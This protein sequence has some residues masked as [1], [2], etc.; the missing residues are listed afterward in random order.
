[1]AHVDNPGRGARDAVER[2]SPPGADSG[3]SFEGAVVVVD[4]SGYTPLAE[5]LCGEDRHGAERLGAI[6]DIGFRGYV[7]T[8]RD[9]GGQIACFAGD[10]FTAYWAAGDGDV[11]AALVR[12][13]DC[14][15]RLH[16]IFQHA[17]DTEADAQPPV[18]I[19][20]GSGRMWG[21]RLGVDDGI[22]LLLAGPAV[23][24]ACSALSHAN[25]GRT[26]VAPE[27]RPLL[28]SASSRPLLDPRLPGQLTVQ[29]VLSSEREALASKAP[30]LIDYAGA[31]FDAWIPQRRS[32]CALFVRIDGL[33]NLTPLPGVPGHQ[34][35]VVAIQ[36]ALRPYTGATGTLIFDDKGLVFNVC[37]GMPH[38]TH[39]DE[40]LEELREMAD[41]VIDTSSLNVHE[42]RERLVTQFSEDEMSR[43]MR[44]SIRSFGFKHGVPRDTA[45]AL[46]ERFLPNPHWVPELR[47]LRGI[48][49][50]V[51]E[52]VLRSEGAAEFMER[53]DDLLEFLI[54]RFQGEGKSYLSIGIGCTGGHHRSV[55]IAEELRRRLSQHGINAAVRHRDMER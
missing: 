19:G 20:I 45:L 9:A 51:S 36:A 8:V 43:P 38:D 17:G 15:K 35:A 42:L 54:P 27:A 49:Q 14:A 29:S 6:L 5:R 13:L 26:Q 46:D 48:H 7:Q 37:L 55:A 39:A 52:Y 25:A 2:D 47:D 31:G 32:I 30:R 21:A 40:L 41:V 34:A 4:I 44:V 28:L 16:G 53:I 50:P 10:A 18:H 11:R 12:A 3:V 24:Q 22:Q 1:M 23:H 33:D